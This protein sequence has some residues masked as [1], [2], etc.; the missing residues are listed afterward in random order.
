M[1]RQRFLI[2]SGIA[3]LCFAAL[4]ALDRVQ[5]QLLLRLR[6]LERDAVSAHGRTAAANPDLVFL[7]IDSDSVGLDATDIKELYDLSGSTSLE[8]RALKLM[9]KSWPWPREVYA[10]VLQRL[11]DAGAKVVAFDL[12]FPT[13]TPGDEPFRLALDRYREH[14]VVASNFVSAASRGF[15]TTGASLTRPPESLIPETSPMDDRVAYSNFWPDED[16]VVRHAQYRITFEQ[17]QGDLP[18]ANSERYLSFAALALSKAG[19]ADAIPAGLDEHLFRFTAAPRHGF[20]PRSLFEIF[21]PEYWKQN[22]QSG[23]FFRGKIVVV[24]AEGNWQHDEHPTPFGSMPGPELHLNAMNAA[25]QHEFIS[26]MPPLIVLLVTVGAGVLAVFVSFTIRSPGLRIAALIAIDASWAGLAMYAFNHASIFIP[27]AAPGL[28]LNAVLLLGLAADFAL[29]RVEKRRVRQTL[30]RYV[31]RDFVREMLD[32]P[33]LFEQSL[34]GVTKRV[35]IL[36][37][38]IRGYSK[39]S[40]ASDPHVLVR[41]LNEY[42]GAMVECVFRFGGT[43]DKFMGDAVMAVWGNVRSAGPGEDAV[44]AVRAALAM[45]EELVRLNQKWRAEGLPELNVGIALNHGPVIVGNIGSPQ[46]MEFTVIGDAV[47]VTWKMQELTKK[48]SAELVVSK[49]VESL[50][51]EH[52]ELQALGKHAL[53]SVPGEWEVFAISQPIARA[54]LGQGNLIGSMPAA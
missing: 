4:L 38:D 43:L 15:S 10:L 45:R 29:E 35:T 34:G 6:A 50:I 39:V 3:V 7:A 22:Y 2:L 28:Q 12:T 37:S 11:V 54:D 51:V 36:F 13:E 17:A 19:Q 48:V 40:A 41:Q 21:V 9:S 30:E 44:A 33:E 26:E 14:A 27:M 32:H 1:L 5:P 52:F 53:H 16:D 31:S 18:E 47:N 23:E 24:G 49:A 25:L 8:A 46:R 20:P 42:L